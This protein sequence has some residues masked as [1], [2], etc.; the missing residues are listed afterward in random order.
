MN[1]R[2]MLR[3]IC[4]EV[5]DDRDD[6]VDPELTGRVI[7]APYDLEQ[8]Q[9]L[10]LLHLDLQMLLLKAKAYGLKQALYEVIR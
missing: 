4:R 3:H 6:N 2:D 5:A 8:M 1:S 7:N 10:E 9:Q